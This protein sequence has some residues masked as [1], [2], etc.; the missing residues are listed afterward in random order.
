[1]RKCAL[2]LLFCHGCKEQ[3]ETYIG[4]EEVPSELTFDVTFVA[5]NLDMG[6]DGAVTGHAQ[7][8]ET[9]LSVREGKVDPTTSSLTLHPAFGGM[10]ITG[11][12]VAAPMSQSMT[13]TVNWQPPAF[14]PTEGWLDTGNSPPPECFTAVLASTRENIA[15]DFQVWGGIHQH[16]ALL[17][18]AVSGEIEVTAWA[19]T[20]AGPTTFF[21]GVDRACSAPF[22]DFPEEHGTP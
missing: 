22:H 2:V 20:T 21:Q 8:V 4:I 13:G 11:V 19:S 15:V 9:H 6:E 5:Q 3:S 18:L 1:M 10:M 14:Q 17:S 12:F 16:D 7:R